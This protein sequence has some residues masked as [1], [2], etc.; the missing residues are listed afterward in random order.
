MNRFGTYPKLTIDF[1]FGQDYP[2]VLP[3]YIVYLIS[4]FQARN[5][6]QRQGSFSRHFLKGKPEACNFI[7]I[8][9]QFALFCYGVYSVTATQIVE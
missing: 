2:H 1:Y 8:C 9:Y 7:S 6:N 3:S 4:L 5:E